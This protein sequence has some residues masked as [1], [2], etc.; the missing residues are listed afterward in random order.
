MKRNDFME[1]AITNLLMNKITHLKLFNIKSSSQISELKSNLQ[2]S[3]YF[4]LFNK[5]YYNVIKKYKIKFYC[6]QC[7][8]SIVM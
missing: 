4:L 8:N 1:Y 7:N 2:L 5:N 6:I 3:S